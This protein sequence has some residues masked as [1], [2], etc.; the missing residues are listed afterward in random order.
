MRTAIDALRSLKRYTAEVLPDEWE[1]RLAEEQAA[2]ERPFALVGPAGPE[3][4]RGPAH[5]A[6]VVFP[7]AINLYPEKGSTPEEALIWALETSE[8]IY[9]GFRMG[10]GYG[11]PMRVPLWDYNGV[12][13]NEV[14]TEGL[15]LQGDD[16]H[17]HG[18]YMRVDDLSVNRVKDPDEPTLYTVAVDV[19]LGWRRVGRLP[20][21]GEI[22]TASLVTFDLDES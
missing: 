18:D 9:Q 8:F 21:A 2:F 6:D 13:L 4:Y 10:V 5:T 19:R 12:A 17:W 3:L 22:P 20:S 11:G 15:R 14:S 1:V 16:D 7:C